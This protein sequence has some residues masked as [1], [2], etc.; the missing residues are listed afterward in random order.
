MSKRDTAVLGVLVALS[1]VVGLLPGT[2]GSRT[3][4]GAALLVH[5]GAFAVAARGVRR[6]RP[7]LRR[8]W[9]AVLTVVGTGLAGSL[10]LTATGT[11]PVA[12]WS[13]VAV[14][15]AALALVPFVVRTLRRPAGQVRATWPDV[16][17]TV[18]AGALLVVQ[19][20]GMLRTAGLVEDPAVAVGTGADIVLVIVLL[21]IFATRHGM[22]PATALV[23]LAGGGLLAVSALVTARADL[24]TG[25][26]ALLQGGQCLAVVALAA[27]AAHPSMRHFG[28]PYA[29]GNLRGEGQRLL[30]V[31]PVF[32]A[33]P[34]LWLLG[35]LGVLPDVAVAVVAPSGYVLA[36]AGVAL[37]ALAVRRAERSADRDPLTD[38]VNRRG[39]PGAAH[40]LR[41]RLR[42]EDLHLCLV[43]LDDF[44]QINDTRGHAVGDALLVEVA[45][46]LRGAVGTH[47]VVSRT[48][49]DEFIVVVWTPP[50]DEEGPADLL[51]TALDTPFEFSGLPYQVSASIGIAPLR[52]G[53]AFDEALVDADIAM[54]AAKQAGKGRA[55]VYRPQLREKVLG[56]LVMQQELRHL[57]LQ[58]GRPEDVGELVVLHQ[59][60]VALDGPQD[61]DHPRVV[62]VEALVR[63]HHPRAGLVTPD[64]FLPQ[65]EAAGLGA[66]LDEHVASRAVADLAH[67][68]SLGLG[69]LHLAVNLGVGS[70]HRH[71]MSRWI[72]DLAARHGI[73]PGRIHLEITEHE[74][75]PD[76]P[77]IAASLREVV[78]AGFRLDLD[79]F[80]IGY[81][82]LSYMRRFPVSTVKL[83]RSL[84]ALA[85]GGDSSLLDGIAA[86]C[87]AMDVG[88]LAEGVERAE[89]VAPL[90]ALGVHR[91]QGHW[92]GTPMGAA[93]VPGYLR[94]VGHAGDDTRHD[95]ALTR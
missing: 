22:A 92:F 45:T 94:R 61:G 25:G 87:R 17:L 82:S 39:L 32:C 12:R 16:L 8:A 91:A 49:G 19:A 88:I 55:Q 52:D 81:T 1:V 67:W 24:L 51:L 41:Q 44:K 58:D 57:L 73:R 53:V 79:D 2:A 70:L 7:A 27:A 21:R 62:G 5:L 13:V 23:L 95:E 6:H 9:A 20:L 47:G 36:C 18:G 72:S 4:D 83:D 75:L 64:E 56:A 59:P 15:V 11:A 46:R 31:L 38:L 10:A 30:S 85:T 37:A 50:H 42:G 43:D 74:E 26:R 14:Q 54:Y 84:T 78:A 90:R 35:V 28:S 40:A 3:A 33:V 76:D 80:G 86:L 65:V 34:V 66:R 29:G 89:Q 93:D 69:G 60:I 71:G 63:W 77:R 48:G 68:D